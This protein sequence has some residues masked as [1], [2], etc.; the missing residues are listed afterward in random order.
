MIDAFSAFV[1]DQAVRLETLDPGAAA[2]HH[3]ACRLGD[4]YAAIAVTCAGGRT[5]THR[6]NPDRR[7]GVEIAGADLGPA[8]MGSVEAAFAAVPGLW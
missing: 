1:A 6:A 2:G 8:E 7:G 5:A 4:D 3:L